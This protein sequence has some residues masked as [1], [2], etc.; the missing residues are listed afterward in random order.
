MKMRRMGS[1]AESMKE[2]MKEVGQKDVTNKHVYTL[3][4]GRKIEFISHTV[5]ASEVE[6]TTFLSKHNRRIGSEVTEKS[7]EKIVNSIKRQQYFPAIAMK[8]DGGFDI[9]DGSRRR[10]AAILANV[11]INLLY[12]IEKLTTQEVKALAKELQ[13][14]EEHSYRDHGSYYSML[15]SDT[16]NPITEEEILQ[17]EEISKAFYL[18]CI[19]AWEVPASLVNL[20]ELPSKIS[21]QQ[22]SKLTKVTKK[23]SNELALKSLVNEIEITS[24]S[25]DE[26]MEIIYEKAGLNTPENKSKP[27]KFVDISKDKFVKIATNKNKTTFEITRGTPTEIEDIEKLIQDYYKIK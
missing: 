4:T 18:R 19:K 20:F 7:V 5:P 23:I 9:S 14:S 26:I 13:T 1:I 25:N 24:E 10:K 15:L 22:F 12:C 8:V 2:Q 11:G 27:R 6:S 21:H 16:E 17:E 3:C